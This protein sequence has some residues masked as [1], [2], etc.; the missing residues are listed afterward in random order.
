MFH[1]EICGY[2]KIETFKKDAD[3]REYGREVK[4]DWFPNIIT[5][6]GLDRFAGGGALFSHFYVGTGSSTP[7]ASDTNMDSF[8]AYTDANTSYSDGLNGS[9]PYYRWVQQTRRFGEG[10][11]AGNLAE[12]GCGWDDNP[13]NALF[14]R[15]LILDAVGSPTTITVLSDEY[16]DVTYEFRVYPDETDATGTT[17]FTGNIG[18]SYDWTLRA[19]RLTT[20][21]RNRYRPYSGLFYS[22][23]TLTEVELYTGSIGDILNVPASNFAGIDFTYCRTNA[24]YSNGT[25]YR[26]MVIEFGLVYGNNALG[27]KSVLLPLNFYD[28]Q[29]EFDTAIPKTSDDIVSLTFRFS[30]SRRT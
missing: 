11:A 9:S 21:G 24:A 3:G 17:I 14:S 5:N 27:I 8:V 12:V 7:S 16:L 29:I 1:S 26:D 23:T 30:W 20:D 2:Y 13:S 6:I 15:A 10:V 25:Y 28:I 18:G 19:A 4:A 22:F